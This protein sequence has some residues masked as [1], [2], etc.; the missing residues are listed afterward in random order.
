ME[1]TRR[2]AGWAL[3]WVGIACILYAKFADIFP[4]GLFGRKRRFMRIATYLYL[5]S[6]GLLGVPLTVAASVVVAF[7]FSGR[8]STPSAAISSSP[9]SR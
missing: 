1:A 5:D 6:N 9:T 3:V 4:P 2:V 7:I 8:R